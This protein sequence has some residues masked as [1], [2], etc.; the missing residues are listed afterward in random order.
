MKNFIEGGCK[1]WSTS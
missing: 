1:P